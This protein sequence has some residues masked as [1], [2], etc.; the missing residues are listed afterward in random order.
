M[1]EYFKVS[2]AENFVFYKVPKALFTDNRYKDVSTDAKM[3]YGLLLDRMHLSV[4]NA[5][6]DKY[7]R[8]YQFFTVKQAEELLHFGHEKICKLF[9]E[10]EQSNLILRKRQGQGKPN[11]IYLKKFS[12]F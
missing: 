4:K 12:Q 1:N 6:V 5:W 10:L 2:E 11:I 8:V 9:R 3:L 7:G